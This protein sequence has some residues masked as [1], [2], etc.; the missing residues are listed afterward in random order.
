MGANNAANSLACSDMDGVHIFEGA[1]C[2][3]S[4][5]RSLEPYS[6]FLILIF[7][8]YKKLKIFYLNQHPLRK[9]V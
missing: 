8:H 1:L 3:D 7:N 9:K 6:K 5:L 4:L 2:H